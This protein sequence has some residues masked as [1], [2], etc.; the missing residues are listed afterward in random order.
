MPSTSRGVGGVCVPQWRA[1]AMRLQHVLALL[2]PFA[3][4]A[5]FHHIRFATLQDS[6][7][8]AGA[9]RLVL[10]ARRALRGIHAFPVAAASRRSAQSL[11]RSAC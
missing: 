4:V 5:L 2:A 6:T 9:A 11:A 1:A 8:L 7:L 3:L 10:P